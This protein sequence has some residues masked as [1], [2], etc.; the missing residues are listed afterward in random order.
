M[1]SCHTAELASRSKAAVRTEST[2]QSEVPWPPLARLLRTEL[3]GDVS[4]ISLPDYL[5]LDDE[6]RYDISRRPC[7]PL[8]QTQPTH[9]HGRRGR[10]LPRHRSLGDTRRA[11]YH[12]GP[13]RSPVKHLV[14]LVPANSGR[15]WHTR[16]IVHRPWHS[17]LQRR[18]EG[19]P[20]R[21][22]FA[23]PHTRRLASATASAPAARCIDP[24]TCSAPCRSATPATGH[25]LDRQRQR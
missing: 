3:H 11:A 9:P 10:H 25:R 1:E 23:S 7:K 19:R 22:A 24:A 12:Y 13:D 6:V 4:I 20:C 21:T 14:M 16:P 15:R 8:E 5:T 2:G 18:R 17:R